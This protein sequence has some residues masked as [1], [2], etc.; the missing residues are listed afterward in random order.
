MGGKRVGTTAPAIVARLRG[1]IEQLVTASTDDNLTAS[2]RR[3][4]DTALR[5]LVLQL[6]QLLL[7][8]DPVR[9]PA[10]I[11]DPTNPKLFGR[12]AALAMIAQ[13]RTRLDKIDPFYGSG[14]YA[15]Y[16]TGDFQPYAPICGT[17]TPIYVGKADPATDA[18][19]S[20]RE[21]GPKLAARLKEHAR[22]IRRATTTLKLSDFEY[23]SLMVQSGWQGAAEDYLISFFQPIWNNE[24][25]LVYGIGKHGDAATTRGN[26]RSPWDTLHPGR[27][28]AGADIVQDAKTNTQIAAE[29]A[30]HFTRVPV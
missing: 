15:L 6:E 20:A 7:R 5:E 24:V 2:A 29:L 27:K 10:A 3:R 4:I 26:R 11:F 1:E 8:L 9:Q 25:N 18:A 28:W 17:E 12:F 21:Q 16:Y 23:R 30:D 14:V 13:D 19:K 22:S